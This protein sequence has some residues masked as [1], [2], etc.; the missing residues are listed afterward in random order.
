M[1]PKKIKQKDIMYMSIMYLALLV[2][3]LIFV[4]G[5][6][7]FP[8]ISDEF[9]YE[10]M[11][12]QLTEKGVY[13]SNHYPLLYPLLIAPAHFFGEYSYLV[14]KILN[15]V[16]SSF[17][18]VI[19]YKI[20]RLY[21]EA[22]PSIACGIFTM[23]IPFQYVIPMCLMSENLYFSLFLLAI[24]LFLKP[25][26]KQM[27]EDIAA[28]VSVGM[29]MLTRHITLSLIPV[30]ALLWMMKQLNKKEK[31]SKIILRG[32]GIC[33][34]ILVVYS[35]WL[36]TKLMQGHALKNIVGFGIAS[37]TNPEQLTL[38][39]FILS[40]SYYFFYVALMAAPFLGLLVKSI[41]GIELKKEERFGWYN[42]LWFCMVGLMGML[43]IAA[44]RHSWKVYY[45]YPE[46]TKM[47]G[48]YVIYI[49]VLAAILATVTLFK[50]KVEF[51]HKWC[52]VLFCYI[53]PVGVLL[54]AYLVEIAGRTSISVGSLID[55][56]DS[57]DGRRIMYNGK[58]FFAVAV[59]SIVL[60]Q[61]VHDFGK[62]KIKQYLTV[63]FLCCIVVTELIGAGKYYTKI[64]N[65]N[66]SAVENGVICY[67]KNILED[68]KAVNTGENTTVYME[69]GIRRSDIVEWLPKIGRLTNF[70][71]VEDNSK[72]KDDTYYVLTTDVEKYRDVLIEEINMYTF[73]K[74]DI[75]FIHINN[76]GKD[77]R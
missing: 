76:T 24:Y 44:T 46:F 21:V 77:E 3:K 67:E 42:Q 58:V 28:A 74:R 4:I 45:N 15:A 51:K 68:L 38:T 29:L 41:R 13:D 7:S 1:D 30:F 56:Y 19:T 75:Y 14:M 63:I 16:Y 18:P 43:V 72:I 6:R 50:K 34:G 73:N 26:E 71:M 23:V 53:M 36:I 27:H 37:K 65:S 70:K 64:K 10:F 22:K 40:F 32:L 9:N 17:I 8:I 49:S 2:F 57:M 20:C 60:I 52:N 48:R 11:S 62:E 55:M 25:Y 12:W 33:L 5:N 66:I 59:I 54:A 39:R 69:E 31:F 47:K 35:P 61:A